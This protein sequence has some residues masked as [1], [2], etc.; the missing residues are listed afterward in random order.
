M[1]T[2]TVAA[3]LQ[4]QIKAKFPKPSRQNKNEWCAA[5]LSEY[6]SVQSGSVRG[7]CVFVSAL[8]ACESLGWQRQTET[9]VWIHSGM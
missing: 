7:C 6:Q 5:N 3:I 1:L 2:S 4:Y 9:K 8:A